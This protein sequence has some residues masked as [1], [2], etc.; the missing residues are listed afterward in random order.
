MKRY[1]LVLIFT[2]SITSCF[3]KYFPYYP[4]LNYSVANLNDTSFL[5]TGLFKIKSIFPIEKIMKGEILLDAHSDSTIFELST[6]KG[7]DTFSFT[8][9]KKIDEKY[10]FVNFERIQFFSKTGLKYQYKRVDT[11]NQNYKEYFITLYV[12]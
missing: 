2:L 5:D 7:K 1:F 10:N 6:S 11:S 12:K 9:K 4:P 8:Y 3:T